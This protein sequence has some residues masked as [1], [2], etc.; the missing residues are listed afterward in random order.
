M[1][2]SFARS[3]LKCLLAAVVGRYEF[4]LT[5]DDESY[6]PA[7]LVTTKPANGMWIKLK[8]VPGW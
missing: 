3:E 6:F 7:G 8:E 5:R 4:S 1:I 2:Y